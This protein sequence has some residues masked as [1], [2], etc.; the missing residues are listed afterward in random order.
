MKLNNNSLRQIFL[1]NINANIPKSRK[2][3]PSPR[4]LLRVFRGK[5]S[6][7][8]KARLIDHISH[9]CHCAHE[10]G[11]ILKAI[12]FE[13]DM[14]QV[15]EKYMDA[16]KIKIFP[17]RLS[18]RFASNLVGFSIICISIGILM[19]SG[20]Y[21]D[22]KY[23]ESAI[24]GIRIIQLQEK[25]IARSSLSFRWERLGDP[26][27]YVYELYDETLYQIWQS[28][29][30]FEN[31]VILPQNIVSRLEKNKPYYWMITAFFSNG[32]NIESQ[33]RDFFLIE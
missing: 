20:I 14:N 19:I 26:E 8:T 30:I 4:K 13:R 15:A 31:N 9:C 10:F 5:K 23:R 27:Y 24:S 6:K 21:D 2:Q 16:K 22:A 25:R 3:C 28:K 29:K 1:S 12:R 17:S 18:W 32:R 33:L 7:K 11:F